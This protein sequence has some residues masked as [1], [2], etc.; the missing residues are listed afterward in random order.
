MAN[1]SI[2]SVCNRTCN[3]CFARSEHPESNTAKYMS[4]DVFE[5]A[6]DFIDRSDIKQA[7]LLGGEPTLHPNFCTFVEQVMAREFHLLLF[8]NGLVPKTVLSCLQKLQHERA[9]FL[10]NIAL[11]SES[12][13][14]HEQ[15]RS[16][17]RL[18]G[19]KAMV[20][21][22][23]TRP[24]IKMDFLLELIEEFGLA[25]W[26]RLGLAHPRLAGNNMH[27]LSRHYNIL[28]QEIS[29]FA[30]KASASSVAIDFDCGFVPCMFP[31]D[32]PEKLKGIVA[33]IGLR[34]NPSI[35]IMPDG[36]AIPCYPLGDFYRI[37]LE[38]EHNAKSLNLM[39]EGKLLPFSTV[40]IFREC[41]GCRLMIEKLC[42]GGCR[43]ATMLRFNSTPFRIA[44]NKRV[45]RGF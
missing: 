31:E 1:I 12:P 11:P 17:L 6:L 38:D 16:F 20:G 5:R 18:M 13:N 45:G 37:P 28:G 39:I 34:C 42:R 22:N 15:Q 4:P 14:E 40:G 30:M 8:T 10:V 29:K 33:Q 35:D 9:R 44:I 26:I 36:S 27:L 7:R 21:L 25:R 43:S 32:I 3:Y 24:N 2:T 23:I 41:S 19:S